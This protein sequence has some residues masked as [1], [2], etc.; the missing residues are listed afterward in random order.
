MRKRKRYGLVSPAKGADSSPPGAGY[1]LVPQRLISPAS[2]VCSRRAS[3]R[4]RWQVKR[5]LEVARPRV[6][7]AQD[8]VEETSLSSCG[9]RWFPHS[10]PS[11]SSPCHPGDATVAASSGAPTLRVGNGPFMVLVGSGFAPRSLVRV[12]V[13]GNGIDRRA[14]V[15]TNLRGRLRHPLARSRPLTVKQATARTIG[16]VL[17]RVPPPWFIR[18]CPP[19]PPLA[20]GANPS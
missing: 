19:P 12:R 10:L 20:P 17:A 18:E 11:L 13:T 2:E 4:G 1:Q 3:T 14:S 8:A 7:S 5:H 15:R 9:S 6:I 16:G